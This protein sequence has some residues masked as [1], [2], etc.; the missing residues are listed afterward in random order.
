MAATKIQDG[1]LVTYDS[2]TCIKTL[3]LPVRSK[4]WTAHSLELE[5]YSRYNVSAMLA[6]LIRSLTVSQKVPGS[7]TGLAMG[8]NI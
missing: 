1:A 4:M 8:L 6:H 2:S 3:I 7:I 5:V